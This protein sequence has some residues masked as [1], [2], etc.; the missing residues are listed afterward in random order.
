MK[1]A[2]LAARGVMRAGVRRASTPAAR[3]RTTTR[4]ATGL[5]EA[6]RAEYPR[7]RRNALEAGTALRKEHDAR[8]LLEVLLSP[9]GK[10]P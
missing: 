7:F 2:P 5:V 3:R 1:A 9:E 4:L 10:T 8:Q 6:V